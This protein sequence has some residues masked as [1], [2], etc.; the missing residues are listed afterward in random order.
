MKKLILAFVCLFLSNFI[1]AQDFI[2]DQKK[3]QSAIE[4]RVTGSFE[5]DWVSYMMYESKVFNEDLPLQPWSTLDPSF[6]LNVHTTYN[7]WVSIGAKAN[8]LLNYALQEEG[9]SISSVSVPFLFNF[10]FDTYDPTKLAS[11]QSPYDG[12]GIGVGGYMGVWNNLLYT[13]SDL[14]V[15]SIEMDSNNL[16]GI[17]EIFWGK[18]SALG[19]IRVM[20]D[21]TQINYDGPSDNLKRLYLSFSSSFFF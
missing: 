4:K 14:E 18:K 10:T 6:Y 20:K 7:S 11:Q 5:L 12:F 2:Q 8:G 19:K 9:Y 15:E 3:K 1:F 13:N 16:G 17:V 21:F